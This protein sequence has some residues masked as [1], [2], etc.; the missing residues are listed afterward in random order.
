MRPA[1]AI[2]AQNWTLQSDGVQQ[3]DRAD[4]GLYFKSI[5]SSVDQYRSYLQQVRGGS[6]ELTNTDFDTGKETKAAEYSLTDE[7]YAKLLGQLTERRFDL[8]SADLRSN[9]LNFYS[10]LSLQ[11]E[12]K[13]NPVSGKAFCRLWTS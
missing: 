5:N 2:H 8:T 11:L 4:G 1:P 10:D 7:T 3:P 12:T 13:Q 6:L 9:I